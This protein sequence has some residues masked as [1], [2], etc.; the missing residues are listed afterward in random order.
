VKLTA[1]PVLIGFVTAFSLT[2]EARQKEPPASKIEARVDPRVELMSLIF[3]LAG[4]EEYNQPLS[5]SPYSREVDEHFGKYR[6]HA[7]VVTAKKLRQ[8]HGVSYDAVMKLAVHLRDT[9]LVETKVPLDPFPPLLDKRWPPDETGEFLKQLRAFVKETGFN[10]FFEQHKKLYDASGQ[11]LTEQLAKRDYIGWLNKFFGERSGGAEFHVFV[12]MLNGPGNYG[13]GMLHPDGHEEI[14]PVIGAS[15]FDAE[16]IPVF[17]DGDVS[18]IAHEFCHS[19]TNV[20]V[21]KYAEQLQP[22]GKK[23]FRHC[24]QVMKRMAYGNWQTMYRESLVRATVVRFLLATDGEKAAQ[25]ESRDNERRG[26]RWVGKLAEVLGEYESQRD[27]YPTFDAFMPRIVDFF[28]SYA[29]EYKG[30]MA[31]APKVVKTIPPNGATD[32]DPGLT[33]IKVFFDRPMKDKSWAVVGGGPHFPEGVSDSWYDDEHKIFSMRVR[34]KPG[35]S[36][37][38]WLNHQEHSAFQ[39]KEGIPLE[40]V[41]VN[42]ETRKE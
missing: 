27:R 29:K 6:D 23:I 18:T 20:F 15:K 40:P 36:Y 3:R 2:T 7:A 11:R 39:S 1:L 33:E 9:R 17:G 4:S 28:N 25:A 5:K 42:F 19:Y 24:R 22:S 38:F 16:G 21:D 13:S 35:W 30:Q 31:R 10:E 41:E 32:V 14:T 34:L 37:Q 12:G 26:F 8:D